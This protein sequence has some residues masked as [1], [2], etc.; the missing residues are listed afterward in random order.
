MGKE[1]IDWQGKV[2]GELP[3]KGE[4]PMLVHGRGPEGARCGTCVFL[5]K[6]QY[7]NVTYQKCSL[8]KLTHGAA[9]D[10]RAKWP[11]CSKYEKKED[12]K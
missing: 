9:S 3:G 7:H 4:N 2:I 11:A 1:L 12:A 8:Y 10:F 5:L 6:G